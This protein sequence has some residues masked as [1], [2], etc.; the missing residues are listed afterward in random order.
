MRLM[1]YDISMSPVSQ[2]YRIRVT[3]Q[4]KQEHVELLSDGRYDIAVNSD[5]KHGRAN[6]RV[7]ELL[8]QFL[9]VSVERVVMTSGHAQMSKRC[10]VLGEK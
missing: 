9:G 5:R 4:A 3:L 10:I 2:V 6:Q 7:R 1:W 8:A